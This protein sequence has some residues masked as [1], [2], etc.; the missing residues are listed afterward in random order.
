MTPT[1]IHVWKKE[2]P[3]NICEEIIELF[4]KQLVTNPK[5]FTDSRFTDS[6]I[7]R[8]DIISDLRRFNRDDLVQKINSHLMK[9]LE[10]YVREYGHLASNVYYF[11]DLKIQKTLPYGGFHAWHYEAGSD[12]ATVARELVWTI[13]L[14]DMPPNEAETEFLYQGIKIKPEKGLLCIFPAG[15]THLHRGL[16]VY[17]HPK[18]ILTGWFSKQIEPVK[19]P[20]NMRPIYE[21]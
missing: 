17:T 3:D 10:F 13:Y 9:C 7:R 21:N 18:Y 6:S 19:D 2:V 15:M 4:E 11:N 20:R 5:V 16:T 1:F 12:F 8:K 14:N